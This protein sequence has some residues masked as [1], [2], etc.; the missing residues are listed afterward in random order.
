M[1]SMYSDS[2]LSWQRLFGKTVLVTGGYGMLASYLVYMLIHIN[3]VNSDAKIKILVLGRDLEKFKSRY[4]EYLDRGYI[5]PVLQDVSGALDSVP[6]ADFIVHA[7][8]HASP[9]VYASNPVDVMIPNSIG[10]FQ[11]LEKARREKAEGFLFFSSG[12]AQGF[13][14][15]RDTIAEDDFGYLNP[16]D[17]RSC[18]GESKRLGEAL[19][20]GYSHQYGLA[21]KV[22]RLGHTYGPT[23]D[24]NDSR[25][26]SCFVADAVAG[27]DICMKSDG[28]A[29]RNF[30][31]ISDAIRGCF[32]VL[33]DGPSGEL[34]N[35][36]ESE[37]AMSV[38]ELALLIARLARRPGTRV[39]RTDGLKSEEYL[40][41]P[42]SLHYPICSSE[43]LKALGWKSRVGVEEGFRRTLDSFSLQQ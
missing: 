5:V 36:T 12:E 1:Q 37:N 32:K 11:L 42:K 13:F 35:V 9:H 17:V 3:E 21:A 41:A 15:G 38:G 33:F 40:E 23:I 7:A 31:Y 18:Y 27:R 24:L 34:F 29:V 28:C 19:C 39:Y 14:E 26:F 10:T 4:G 22:V 20:K 8:S 30:C 16:M 6:H 2:T 25:V 43:K